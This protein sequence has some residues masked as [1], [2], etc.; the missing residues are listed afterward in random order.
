MA[1]TMVPGL[2]SAGVARVSFGKGC[3][4]V[5]AE[6]PSTARS[7]CA[8]EIFLAFKIFALALTVC[9]VPLFMWRGWRDIGTRDLSAWQPVIWTI[10]WVGS[11]A[12][13]A[14]LWFG[15]WWFRALD[16]SKLMAISGT[17]LEISRPYDRNRGKNAVTTYHVRLQ[18]ARGS[19]LGSGLRSGLRSGLGEMTLHVPAQ[20]LS[21]PLGYLI[22]EG[23]PVYARISPAGDVYE[24]EGRGQEIVSLKAA[25][26]AHGW[27]SRLFSLPATIL[28]LTWLV[29][30]MLT[31]M[32]PALQSFLGPMLRER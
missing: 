31:L 20:A 8:V 10:L 13:I 32:W 9:A 1:L 21:R 28:S 3:A 30:A 18:P 4:V 29:L 5:S 16:S 23:Q 24:L 15:A 12:I 27:A 11:L 17:V 7:L 26:H 2:R 22:G 14:A 25:H 19:G 6:A